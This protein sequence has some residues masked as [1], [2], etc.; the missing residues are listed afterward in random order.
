MKPGG[1]SRSQL[2][3]ESPKTFVSKRTTTK[4]GIHG[5]PN[6]RD[7][8]DSACGHR[9]DTFIRTKMEWFWIGPTDYRRMH[10]TPESIHR[11]E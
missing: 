7:R 10:H 8:E 9:V 3:A 5:V 11:V 6:L 1:E 4:V 2:E